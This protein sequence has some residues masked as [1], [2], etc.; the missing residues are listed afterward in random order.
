MKKN[1]VKTIVLKDFKANFFI[2]KAVYN[3]A[4]A[5]AKRNDMTFSQLVRKL[6]R[7]YLSEQGE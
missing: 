1:K 7:T 3:S 6:L 5:L 4:A 2:E